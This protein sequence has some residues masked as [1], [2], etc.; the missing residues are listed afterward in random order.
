MSGYTDSVGRTAISMVIS[1]IVGILLGLLSGL[2][3]GGGSLLILWLTLI[4]EMEQNTA[5]TINLLF[6][7]PAAVISCYYRKKQG[8]LDM[9]K[10]LPAMAAGCAG[11]IV[12]TRL[13]ISLDTFL[14]KKGFGILLIVTAIREILWKPKNKAP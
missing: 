3:I 13:G 5:R 12:G 9:R 7:I 1:L 14:L 11:A 8:I 10:M 4:L 6:F 2:G